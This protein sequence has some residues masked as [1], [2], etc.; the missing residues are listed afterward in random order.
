MGWAF[1]WLLVRKERVKWDDK[2][3]DV[4]YSIH[5]TT[6]AETAKELAAERSGKK[7]SYG[8]LA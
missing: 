3:P 4:R 2:P 5:S 8:Q 6:H 7:K 1:N